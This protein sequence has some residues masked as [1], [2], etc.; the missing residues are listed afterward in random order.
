MLALSGHWHPGFQ[1]EKDGCHYI[2]CPALGKNPF[3]FCEIVVEEGKIEQKIYGL[4]R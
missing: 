4:L 3:Q 1:V 2:S